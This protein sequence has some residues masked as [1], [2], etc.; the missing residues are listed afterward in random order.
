[1]SLKANLHLARPGFSLEAAF[2]IPSRGITVVYGPSGCGKTTLLR[3]L[4]GL[5]TVC[6][7]HLAMENMD[8]Q[9]E[10]GYW[11]PPHLREAA[12]VFQE[13]SLFDHLDVR[14]NLEFGYRRTPGA[15][16][17]VHPDQALAF[18]EAENLLGRDTR[19]LSGGERQKIAMARAL[20][21]SPRLLLMDEP[22]SGLDRAARSQILP[23]LRRLP[24]EMAIPLVYVTHSRDEMARLA[25]TLLLMDNGKISVQGGMLEL[26][27]RENSPLAQGNDAEAVIEATVLEHD[28]ENHLTRL[29]FDGGRLDVSFEALP[30]GSS[31]RVRVAAR[32]VSLA[33]DRAQ[34]SS[35][36][37]ILECEVAWIRPAGEGSTM[38]GLKA[39][40]STLLARITRKSTR[41]L[42]LEKGKRVFAQVKGVAL[43]A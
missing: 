34:R 29:A 23:R 22:L 10:D 40:P 9:R 26:L 13:A 20:L 6:K 36:L 38:L 8:W 33:L 5:E 16:R 18:F 31:V 43:R 25:D 19:T 2:E 28:R 39:G 1:M 21:A 15:K 14:E 11:M 24:L 41:A 42:G 12:M 35:I 30:E 37:N 4:A 32:D 27:T 17:R 3:C 7:G